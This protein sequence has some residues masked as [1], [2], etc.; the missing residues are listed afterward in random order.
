MEQ[1]RDITAQVVMID[2]SQIEPNKGQIPDLPRNPRLIR[3]DAY[4]KLVDSL[5][6][7]PDFFIKLNPLKV[8]PFKGK[9]VI[10][11]GNMRYHA[12]RDKRI[13]DSWAKLPCLIIPEDTDN[14]TL[15][16][17]ILLDNASFGEWDPDE[18]ANLDPELL[19]QFCIDVP[20]KEEETEEEAEEDNYD[21]EGNRPSAA[22]AKTHP[23]DIYQLGDHR[24]ICGDSTDPA[25]LQ[26]L[27]GTDI[28]DLMI[29]DPPYNVNYE[30]KST[31]KKIE[32]D[33]MA[34]ALFQEFLTDAFT[35][36]NAVMKPGAP[37]YI[38]HADSEGFNFRQAAKRTGWTVRQCL[39]WNKN[40]LVLGRQDYQWKHEPCLYGWKDGTG[41]YFTQRRDLT[42][43]QETLDK[44]DL[45]AMT[46]QE[47]KDLLQQIMDS[48]KI[49]TTVIDCDK[50]SRSEDYPTM[51]PLKLIGRLITN[52]S[53]PG[54]T[55]LDSF[56]GS[57]STMMAAEQL[58][59]R[60]LMVELDPT[61]CDV[62]VK[63]WEE[64]TGRQAVL[65]ERGP[66]PT[67]APAETD[68][69]QQNNG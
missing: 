39:I 63:R 58:G 66:E 30:S 44:I 4:R 29:T 25:V 57:G 45:N 16:R 48:G 33:N 52:S 27:L 3:N 18:L 22:K 40:S 36:A 28:V 61:Y 31:G 56:G 15:E 23:G 8:F 51:K 17:Y 60:C 24:L 13:I 21:A 34:D 10:M 41:H 65:T 53:R 38:W 1:E 32:N 6:R 64:L 42:T 68:A 7:D 19:E 49:P 43:V 20:G 2:A 35:A 14:E 67:E 9:Y 59:R 11:G 47:M 55:I 5:E 26:R 50:P 62:I 37:F 46:K 69:K 12:S 54:E